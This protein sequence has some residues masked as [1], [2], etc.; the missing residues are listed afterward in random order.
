MN[1]GEMVNLENN[2]NFSQ[3]L[4]EALIAKLKG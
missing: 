4:Q 2:I 1:S 3:T